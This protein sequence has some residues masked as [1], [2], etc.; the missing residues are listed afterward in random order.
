MGYLQLTPSEFYD[1]TF[2]ELKIMAE[3]KRR[4]D[5]N[6]M[7]AMYEVAR[8]QSVYVLQPHMKKGKKLK[9]TDIAKFPWEVDENLPTPEKI[10]AA[11]AAM[12]EK[13]GEGKKII[14]INYLTGERITDATA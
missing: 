7:R 14:S 3:G 8:F 4:S 9:L 1:M 13:W 2:Q 6:Q 5:E 11:R 10:A 12:Y